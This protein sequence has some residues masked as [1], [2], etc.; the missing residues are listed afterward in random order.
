MKLLAIA[1][2]LLSL[3]SK[4][5]SNCDADAKKYCQGVDP[6]KGQLAKCLSD[7]EGSLSAACLKE[8]KDF[9]KKTSS[10]NPCFEDLADLCPDVP[11][12]GPK[13]EL[14]LLKNEARLSSTCAKDFAKKKGNIITR[15]VCALDIVSQCYPQVTAEDGAINHCLIRNRAKLSGFC[16]KKTEERV[17]KMKKENPCFEETE[18]HCPAYVRFADIQECLEKRLNN[19]PAQ[20]KNIVQAEIKKAK[21]N[22]CYKDLTR[23]CVPNITP[24]QQHECLTLNEEHLSNAC[25]QFRVQEKE[26]VNKMV[27]F[28]ENDRLKFCAKEPFENGRVAKCLRQNKAKLSKACSSLL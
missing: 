27:K 5:A 7:Y 17:A 26:K 24:K 10:K 6:G 25:R 21:A 15:N 18:K 9:K 1:L 13:L 12:E 4:A 8:L 16:K 28:C 20:C 23:H 3:N 14:C 22:P 19:L 11:S 2:T